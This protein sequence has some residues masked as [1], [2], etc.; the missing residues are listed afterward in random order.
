MYIHKHVVYA[1]S[2]HKVKERITHKAREQKRDVGFAHY[3]LAHFWVF[4]CVGVQAEEDIAYA[5][6]EKKRNAIEA[7]IMSGVEGWEVGAS[8]YNTKIFA[9]PMVNDHSI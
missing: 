9:L 8:V 4:V 6:K 3:V 7:E 5:S 2:C 1:E